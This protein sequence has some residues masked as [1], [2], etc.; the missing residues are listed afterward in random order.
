LWREDRET[1][2]IKKLSLNPNQMCMNNFITKYANGKN[3]LILL[4][5][6]IVINIF[7]V[8]AMGGNPNLQPLDLQFSYSPD[9][10]Y[11]LLG[12]YN[13]TERFYYMIAEL[14]LDILY[15]LV[16]GALLSFILYMLHKNLKFAK[17][18]FDVVIIDYLEN[19]GIVIMLLNYPTRIDWL[20]SLTGIFTTLKWLFLAVILMLILWGLLKKL[21]K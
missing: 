19:I 15:P 9:R 10:A 5:L 17:L 3:L 2:G 7:L 1:C 6:V 14:T 8:I 13:E 20:A 16:Y 21:K 12:A 18:P 4:G 11:E